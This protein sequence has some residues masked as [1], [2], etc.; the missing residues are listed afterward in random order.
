MPS[1]AC[2][3]NTVF[4]F[5]SGVKPIWWYPDLRSKEEKVLQFHNLTNKM[6]GKG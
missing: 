6:C 2:S 1:S 3:D 5:D 4:G